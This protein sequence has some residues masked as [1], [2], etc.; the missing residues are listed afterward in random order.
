MLIDP[1]KIQEK[2]WGCPRG[3]RFKT[4]APPVAAVTEN[5]EYNSGDYCPYC[6]VNFF[7]EVFGGVYEM[8]DEDY[9]T[10]RKEVED[11]DAETE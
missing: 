6:L 2:N 1:N 8:T 7:R 11:K 10:E 5:P 4:V 3:H 9:E